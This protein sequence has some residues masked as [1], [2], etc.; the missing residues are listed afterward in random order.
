MQILENG[1]VTSPRG[2]T[3][4]AV[5]AEIKYTGR[6]DLAIVYSKVPAQAAAVYTL[7]R[8][9][10]APLR[11]TEE[12][13]SNGVAQAIVVNSGIANAGMGAEGMRLAREMSDCAAEALDI[14]KDDVIVASTGVIGMPLPMDRVKAGVQK[15]AKA[16][17]P[18][19]GH[20]AAKAIMTTDTVCKEM[21]VQLRIDGKLVTIGAM[22]KGSGMI[23]PNMATMLGFITT[24]VNIDNKA[25][26][27][28]F[29]ANID[30]SFNMVSVDG[31]TSTNDMVVILANGQAGNTLLTEESPDFPA[32]KQALREICIEMAQKIA[33][34]G[35]GATKLVECTVTGAATKEDARLAAKAIIASSLVKTAIYGNDANWGR[36]ACAAGYSGA[37]FDPDKVNIFIGDVQVAQN[38]MG[39]E[40]DEAKATETL[41]QKKV[42]I[43]VK[44]NIGTEEATAWGCDLTYDYVSINADYRS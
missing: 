8:F 34:D 38:G 2:F 5:A 24:D 13:I 21:A 39:L 3:A 28:A 23:H 18:D 20:D 35:E 44:F 41:K 37:Q 26:Q 33:G 25:L 42:N 15:A 10:A 7:N 22:A 36:I 19:G 12:N 1:S 40:F 43:L 4:A 31:D 32:F 17:Y 11:V 14:A 9:K 27:A 6:T 30:D 16:L 29:K